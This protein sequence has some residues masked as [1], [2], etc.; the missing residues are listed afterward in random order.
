[1][2]WG[3]LP[4]GMVATLEI[5]GAIDLDLVDAADRDIGEHA[6]GVAHDVDVIGDRPG[7]ERLEEREWRLR[8]EHLDLARIFQ[9]EPDL[10]TIRRGGDIGAERTRCWTL[11]TILWSATVMTAVSGVN[12]EQT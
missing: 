1:M 11:P 8:V 2:P 10:G 3:S 9:R 7:V 5:V 12:D 6:V 4:T